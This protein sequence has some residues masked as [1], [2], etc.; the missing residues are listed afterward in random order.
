[1][2]K[3][4]LKISLPVRAGMQVFNLGI[5]GRFTSG[6]ERSEYRERSDCNEQSKWCE[7]GA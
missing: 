2:I 5:V 6:S 7:R 3:G 1:M 4:D